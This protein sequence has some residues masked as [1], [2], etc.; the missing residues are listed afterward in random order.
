MVKYGIEIFGRVKPG[1]GRIG[2]Y[3]CDEGD[4]GYSYVSFNI[5]KDLA[6]DFI[7]NKKEIYKFRFNKAF[8][9]DT[10]QDDIFEHVARGV[11]DN[12][13]SGYNGTIFAYGQTGSGKTFT[14]TGGAERYADRGIIPRTLSYMFECFEKNPEYVYTSHVSY[15]EVYNENGYDLLDPKH[16]AAKL[17]DLPKIALM[18]DNDGNIHLKN[19]SL[20]QANNEE[21]ALNWLF[22]GDTNR[23]IAET[24]MNQASTRSH[25][26]FT[27]HISSRE[28]GSATLRRAKLHL[29]DLAGSE[30]I[31]KTGVDG[32]ILTE[33]KYINLSLHYLEQVIV[34]LSEKSRTH[35]PYR[36]SMLTSVLRDSLG[37]N[38]RTTMIATLSVDR[39]NIDESISTCRF[40]QRV[41]MIK[42]DAVLNEEIDPK[43]MIIKL[44]QEIQQLKDELSM[45]SGMEYKGELTEEEIERLK[46]MIKTYIEDKDPESS[47][48]VGADM[49][50]INL[51]FKLFKGHVLDR[52]P[53]NSPDTARSNGSLQRDNSYLS[54]Q[55]EATKL[56]E[57][58]HQ[59]DNEIS[60]L[61]RHIEE[62][63]DFQG[64]FVCGNESSNVGE[65]QS[66]E[67][68]EDLKDTSQ[69]HP[70]GP[71]MS[72]CVSCKTLISYQDYIKVDVKQSGSYHEAE[73]ESLY[74]GGES[75]SWFI[76]QLD[77]KS[78]K[79]LAKLKL[80]ME[81]Y[82]VKELRDLYR[83]SRVAILANFT[84]NRHVHEEIMREIE[85]CA[86]VKAGEKRRQNLETRRASSLA[87]YNEILK[88]FHHAHERLI[89]ITQ[90]K[91][92]AEELH[93]CLMER[94]Q[95][96]KL[97]HDNI[98]AQHS[99]EF[100]PRQQRERKNSM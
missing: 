65:F 35:I 60:I 80:E 54:D 57:L 98:V 25:C 100:K 83:K 46:Y 22:L 30:R 66:I 52:K 32:T 3:D 72:C 50:K 15:L 9:R 76:Q 23:M 56:K 16:E 82:T 69:C 96:A 33:A 43:L 20:H 38:C 39:K 11:I 29:V 40:A 28:P 36:N 53:S 94:L 45:S 13:L 42:N 89:D 67:N 62:R 85:A 88:E 34:A 55:N 8:D 63:L 64:S 7:N 4:D 77:L 79:T 1:K 97:T 86:V 87:K 58:I 48:L 95:K 91:L 12:V 10:K 41:A 21:E 68:F 84:N 59:R 90:M 78:L 93:T 73:T 5:P 24:P 70:T 81:N 74:L 75:G 61:Y 37:G 71:L 2:D 18:E 51:S 6:R 99:R 92:E 47:L 27:I 26:I 19:L 17:E 44:K 31:H 49:R 14:I